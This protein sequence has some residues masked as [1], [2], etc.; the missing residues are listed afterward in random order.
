MHGTTFEFF[1]M[2]MEQEE[3]PTPHGFLIWERN[4]TGA[5]QRFLFDFTSLSIYVQ[6]IGDRSN[7]ANVSSARRMTFFGMFYAFNHLIY[8]EVE[9]NKSRNHVITW[10]AVK[11]SRNRNYTYTESSGAYENHKGGD[12]MLEQM[13]MLSPKGVMTTEMWG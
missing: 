3:N 7:D 9:Y 11:T 2:Y 6:R 12:F 8:R 4:V 1:R 10:E 13:K 5:T